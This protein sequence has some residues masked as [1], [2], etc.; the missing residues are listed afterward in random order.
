MT[1]VLIKRRNWDT[2][3]PQSEVGVKRQREKTAIYKTRKKAWNTF[4]PAELQENPFLL[5]KPPVC[6]T[7][8]WR[9]PQTDA[10]DYSTGRTQTLPKP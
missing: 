10:D 2:E 5:L 6:G 1:S 8:F 4:F 7:W 3:T 9:P